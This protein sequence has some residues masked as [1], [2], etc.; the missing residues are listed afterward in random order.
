MFTFILSFSDQIFS[1]IFW[2]AFTAIKLA[3]LSCCTAFSLFTFVF[4]TV[5][6]GENKW[7]RWR[8]CTLA[9]PT[10]LCLFSRRCLKWR[11]Y[12]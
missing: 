3:L 5:I 9:K 6:T 7:R 8:W 11:C 10:A 4:L 1:Y 12:V 2:A